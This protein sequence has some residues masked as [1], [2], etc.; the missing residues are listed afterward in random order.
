MLRLDIDEE[1]LQECHELADSITSQVGKELEDFSTVSVERAVARLFSVEG[2]D[3]R[4]VPTCNLMVE[5]LVQ[6]GKIKTALLC[7]RQ[8]ML[9]YGHSLI[10]EYGK[11]TELPEVPG[12]EARRME[13]I[14]LAEAR[15]VNRFPPER[16]DISLPVPKL[17]GCM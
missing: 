16:Q 10:S 3:E 1:R 12:R 13:A 5:D 8:C 17:H 14:R 4:G 9:Y 6:A 15:Q 7:T 11:R 2:A